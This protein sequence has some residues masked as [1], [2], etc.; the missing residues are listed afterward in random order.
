MVLC[1]GQEFLIL[2]WGILWLSMGVVVPLSMGGQAVS[3]LRVWSDV[4]S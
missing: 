4:E 2:S 1:R 3:D